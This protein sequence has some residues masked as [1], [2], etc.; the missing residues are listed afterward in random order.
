MSDGYNRPA[1]MPLVERSDRQSGLGLIFTSLSLL[2]LVGIA[3]SSSNLSSAHAAGITLSQGALGPFTVSR[4]NSANSL[5]V[6]GVL[7]VAIYTDTTS[8]LNLVPGMDYT[9][10]DG[11]LR[12]PQGRWANIDF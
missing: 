7:P 11:D 8:A 4:R 12:Q 1:E 5:R 9:L 2:V 6:I 10:A 3:T